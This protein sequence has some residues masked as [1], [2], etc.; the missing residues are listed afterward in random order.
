M[1]RRDSALTGPL[2]FAVALAALVLCLGRADGSIADNA[3]QSVCAPPIML[4][5]NPDQFGEPLMSIW[6]GSSD[7]APLTRTLLWVSGSGN[8]GA[9]TLA[10]ST[11]LVFNS[12]FNGFLETIRGLER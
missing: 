1:A 10:D 3:S 5:P 6:I 11:E 4:T 7:A 9:A 8:A 12:A 2:A